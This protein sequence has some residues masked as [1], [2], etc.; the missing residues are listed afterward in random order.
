MKL[1]EMFRELTHTQ[2][3]LKKNNK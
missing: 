3:P 1:T 2:P